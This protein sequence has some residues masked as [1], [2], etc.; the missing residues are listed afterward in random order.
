MLVLSA[1]EVIM[2]EGERERGMRIIDLIA[3][4][5]L[6]HINV[7]RRVSELS[8]TELEN[9]APSSSDPAETLL[10]DTTSGLL[11]SVLFSRSLA[12]C[13]HSFVILIAFRSS[14]PLLSIAGP[15]RK[16]ERARRR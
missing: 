7:N 10:P 16:G 14:A 3:M 4:I 12:C 5:R 11:V 9:Q 2:L 8:Q 13:E 15:E 1:I 6:E